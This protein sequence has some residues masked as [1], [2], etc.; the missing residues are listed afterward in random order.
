MSNEWL[1]KHKTDKE[2]FVVETDDED[3]PD[4]GNDTIMSD[5]SSG[6]DSEEDDELVNNP[7]LQVND[8]VLINKNIIE[9]LK[10]APAEKNS[11]ISLHK[12]KHGEELTFLK[13]HGGQAKK[14]IEKRTELSF[15]EAAEC[16]SY[17]R[18]YD[19]RCAENIQFI[20]YKLKKL[21][22]EKLNSAISIAIKKHSLSI[23]LT[24]RQAIDDATYEAY[25]KS[26]EAKRFLRTV[27]S[28]PEYWAMKMQQVMAMNRQLG[29]G[30]FFTSLSPIEIDWPELIKILAKVL[31]NLNL[32]LDEAD[33]L[34]KETKIDY[35][36]RDPVTVARYFEYRRE[37]LLKYILNFTC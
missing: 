7:L 28:T 24:A 5:S 1:D 20:F 26:E 36:R 34:D 3:A 35:L 4:Q 21:L 19:R 15:T 9:E 2:D 22:A 18:R 32:S 33:H 13:I 10:I 29:P 27:R 14:T 12:D 25:L 8:T 30:T 31:D 37:E 23:P 6:T 11:P 16:K 17:F